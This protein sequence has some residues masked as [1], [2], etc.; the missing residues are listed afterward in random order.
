MATELDVH[1]AEYSA[2]T[3]RCTYFTNIQNVVLSAFIG[4]LTFMIGFMITHPT[5]YIF[6]GTILGS[7]V[8]GIISAWL[9]YE[10]YNIVRYL[11]SSLRPLIMNILNHDNFWQY[12]VYNKKKRTKYYKVWES[13]GV[14]IAFFII[15]LTTIIRIVFRYW[16]C[17]GDT[18]GLA[19]NLLAFILYTYRTYCAVRIRWDSWG[20]V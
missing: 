1:I 2:L 3:T 17:L 4:W 6:W 20:K 18:L 11:E 8:F 16:E 10:E 15:F 9:L 12:Q 14:I 19:L 5:Y 7:Q 13:F